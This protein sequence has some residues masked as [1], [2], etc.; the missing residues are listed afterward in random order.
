MK[1]SKMITNMSKIFMFCLSVLAFAGYFQLNEADFVTITTV[2]GVSLVLLVIG[3][4]MP[5]KQSG[6]LNII[7]IQDARGIYTKATV[8]VYN[9]MPMVMSFMRSFFKV[10][11]S[12]TRYISI[13]VRRGTE[14]MAVDVIRG[15]SGNRNQVTR[16]TE[17]IFEPPFFWE[18]FTVSEMQTY[19]LAIAA[20]T[21]NAMMDLA[22]E[23]AEELVKLRQKIERRYEYMCSQVL[24][25]GIVTMVN[26]D[27]IDFQRKADSLVDPGAGNYWATT[28]ID[29]F[30][31]IEAGCQW[32]RENGKAQGAT[33]NCIMGTSAYRDFL[34]SPFYTERNKLVKANLDSINAPQRNSVG[35]SYH[36]YI[37]AGTFIVNIWTYN[38][39]FEN[40][41]G[42]YIPY[43]NEKTIVILPENPNFTLSYGAVPQLLN[44]LPQAIQGEFIIIPSIIDERTVTE[45]TH[46]KSAGVP[47]PLAVDQIYTRKVVA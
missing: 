10:T 15:T 13:E 38:E 33:M 47:I 19:D 30:A 14:K 26:G 32:V 37:S 18:Y 45:E 17:K 4:I 8:A 12:R 29:P 23:S 6:V 28:T 41:A 9:E 16:S 3:M 31:N 24:E 5:E 27:N 44:G 46:I 7:S 39:I 11:T 36:G 2:G 21:A 34:K 43:K 25:T 22:K 42:N 40:S 1:K 35:G 20:M